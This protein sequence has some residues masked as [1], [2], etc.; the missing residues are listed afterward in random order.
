MKNGKG[1]QSLLEH[2]LSSQTLVVHDNKA[3][4]QLITTRH[5]RRT[6][7]TEVGAGSTRHFKVAVEVLKAK[8]RG[9]NDCL[10]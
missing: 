4:A 7:R 10:C 1:G 9:L 2:L 3:S 8:Q 5:E 6:P